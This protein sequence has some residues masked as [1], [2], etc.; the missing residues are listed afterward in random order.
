MHNEATLTQYFEWQYTKSLFVTF[1]LCRYNTWQICQCKLRIKIKKS[2]IL[3]MLSNYRCYLRE[4]QTHYICRART[5]ITLGQKMVPK[6]FFCKRVHGLFPVYLAAY[7]NF[8]SDRNHKTRRTNLQKQ[9][10]SLVIFLAAL[11]YGKVLV[12]SCKIQIHIKELKG[13]IVPFIK[14]KSN[15][16]F[17]MHNVYDVKLLFRVRINFNHLDEHKVGHGFKDKTKSMCDYGST[18]E[19]KIIFSFAMP[20]ILNNNIKT[21]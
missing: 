13:K 10:F 7:I 9:N 14:I 16:V 5:R 6:I 20:G 17:S 19:T 3:R 11:K 15:P 18:T 8:A 1:K 2:L 12:L 4:Q 21:P